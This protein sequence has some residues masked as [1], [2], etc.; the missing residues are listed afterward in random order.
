MKRLLLTGITVVAMATTA[1]AEIPAFGTLPHYAMA[2]ESEGAVRQH[3]SFKIIPDEM[4]IRMHN[5]KG[6]SFEFEVT[7]ANM[8]Q[9]TVRNAYGHYVAEPYAV[10][11]EFRDHGGHIRGFNAGAS[12]YFTYYFPIGKVDQ[13]WLYKCIPVAP[14]MVK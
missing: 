10:W 8:S 12:S 1:Y 3:V 11:L 5:D 4:L 13:S 2:C 6:E 9:R 7:R 14:E